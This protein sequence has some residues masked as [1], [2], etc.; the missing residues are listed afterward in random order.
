MAVSPIEL[1]NPEGSDCSNDLL[2]PTVPSTVPSMAE[3]LSEYS[4]T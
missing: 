1:E 3:G 4:S 2:S